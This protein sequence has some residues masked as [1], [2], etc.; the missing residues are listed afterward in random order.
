M[1]RYMNRCNLDKLLIK[2]LIV[3]LNNLV[4]KFS[5]YI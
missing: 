3:L 5:L 2:M 4:G 1:D